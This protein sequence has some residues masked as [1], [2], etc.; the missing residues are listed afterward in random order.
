[1]EEKLPTR[2]CIGCEEYKELNCFYFR[3]KKAPYGRC[4]K[5]RN[6]VGKKWVENNKEK[7]KESANKYARR[8]TAELST[9]EKKIIAKKNYQKYKS[10]V[11]LFQVEYNIK[12]REIIR[13][14][15]RAYDKIRRKKD[16]L[17]KLKESCRSRVKSILKIKGIKKQNKNIEILGATW[18]I[19]KFHLE[20]QFKKGMTWENHGEW[21]I[22]HIIP[23]ASA[24]N[25]EEVILLFHYTNL[26]PLWAKEN[27]EKR[28]KLPINHQITL[29]I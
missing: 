21:H 26:Q 6:E 4:K 25:K 12:N 7:R 19:V 9:E 15:R 14:K 28:D 8:R 20:R 18:E 11:K 2:F 13:E 3:N 16:P 29:T 24:K 27:V 1:M 5:C 22:D 23:I 17:W 10:K